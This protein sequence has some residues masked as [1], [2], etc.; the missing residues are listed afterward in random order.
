[1]FCSYF[2]TLEGPEGS[3]K[4]TRYTRAGPRFDDSFCGNLE[5]LEQMLR[6]NEIEGYKIFDAAD[7]GGHLTDLPGPYDFVYS[8]F[9]IGWHWSIE[10]FLDEIQ[11]LMHDRAVGAFTLHPKFEDYQLFDDLPHRIVEFRRSWPRG[12]RSE[13]LILAR[14]EEALQAG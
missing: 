3:G 11:R 6:F 14:T 8:F 10:H 5:V 7:M 4:T 1:M 2:I 13:M 12:R 9:A